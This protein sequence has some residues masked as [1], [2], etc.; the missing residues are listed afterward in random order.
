MYIDIVHFD[1]CFTN[2]VLDNVVIEYEQCVICLTDER[3]PGR[4]R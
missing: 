2:L 3:Q 4:V 1:Q